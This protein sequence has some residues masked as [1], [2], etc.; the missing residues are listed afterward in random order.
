MHHI[1]TDS[2]RNIVLLNSLRENDV[3]PTEKVVDEEM[4]KAKY[5]E[6][7]RK[8]YIEQLI[9]ALMWFFDWLPDEKVIK[10]KR[11]SSMLGV[12]ENNQESSSDD[13]VE[14]KNLKK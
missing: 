11:L 7:N 3:L 12:M 9:R 6:E 10:I 1:Q 4:D 5:L 14:M 13:D 2:L 8:Q